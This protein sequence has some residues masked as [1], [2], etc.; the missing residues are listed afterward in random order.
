MEHYIGDTNIS[1]EEL[2]DICEDRRRYTCDTFETSGNGFDATITLKEENLV[3]F[4][5]PYD[6]GWTAT[7]NG[8][9]VEIEKVNVGFMG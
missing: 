2:T 8:E 7:V 3:F 5:V 4:S 9:P 6:K 1:D